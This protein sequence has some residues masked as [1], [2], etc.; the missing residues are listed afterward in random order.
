MGEVSTLETELGELR[1]T[2]ME[3]KGQ[4]AH[5][6]SQGCGEGPGN[7]GWDPNEGV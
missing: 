7:W 4:P 2:S 5:G 6:S 3:G 1:W